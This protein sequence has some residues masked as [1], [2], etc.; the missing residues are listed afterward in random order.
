MEADKGVHKKRYYKNQLIF[1]ITAAISLIFMSLTILCGLYE[2][3]KIQYAKTT[4]WMISDKDND[5]IDLWHDT[6]PDGD[7]LDMFSDR[8][9]NGDGIPN[10]DQAAIFALSL[11]GVATDLLM[12][13]FGNLFGKIGHIVCI[14]VPVRSYLSCGVSMPAV[15]FESARK[16]PG[17][18]QISEANHPDNEFFYRRVRNYYDLFKNHPGLETSDTPQRGDW[19]FYG[20]DHIALVISVDEMG[21]Y[22]VME[23]YWSKT[24][25][26]TNIEIEDQ[27]GKPSFFGRIKY[28]D[29]NMLF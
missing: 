18:F 7:G 24:S 10:E 23:A 20:R 21:H 27:W 4:S 28:H 15:L 26:S 13:K 8:D 3:K 25:R 29:K 6:D 17:W 9:A 5:G 22:R 11:E 12:G 19:V 1:I 2:Y 16:S 14:D